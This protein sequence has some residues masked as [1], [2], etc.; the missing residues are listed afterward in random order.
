MWFY[1]F[2]P[3]HFPKQ[4]CPFVFIREDVYIMDYG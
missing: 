2:S 4:A 1:A 3:K